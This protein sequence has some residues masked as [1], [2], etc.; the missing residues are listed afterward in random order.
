MAYNRDLQE[1]KEP[2]FDAVDQVRL[3]VRAMTGL[4]STIAFP[5]PDAMAAAADA[6]TMAATDLAEY[7]VADGVPFR[8][9]H[10]IVGDL[11]RRSLDGEAPL[12]HLVQAHPRLGESRCRPAGP[13][14]G[15]HPAHHP[16][17]A[18]APSQ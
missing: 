4:M 17:E 15:R 8:D 14:R 11:V 18:Q 16:P 10:A 1:D 9:A 13:R 12:V 7:L 2:L 3:G 5:P 6:P